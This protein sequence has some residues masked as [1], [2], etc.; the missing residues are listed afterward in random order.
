M[1]SEVVTQFIDPG[2]GSREMI[3]PD[4]TTYKEFYGTGWQRG[5]TMQ[6][7]VWSGGVRQKWTTAAWTQD[8]TSVNYQT[9]PRVTE[10]NVY[11]SAGNRRRTTVEY[12]QGYGLPTQ[13][14]EYGADGQTLLA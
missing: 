2:D 12:N 7:E 4:G 5:L 13:V 9:N 11:D 3:S 8:N 10:T 14:R 1:P 6:S